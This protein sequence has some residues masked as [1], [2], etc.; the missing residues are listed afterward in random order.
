MKPFLEKFEPY[1]YAALRIVAGFLFLWHGTSKLFGFP[2]LGGGGH[3]PP[4]M[5]VA[6][7][8]ES[9]GGTLMLLGLFTPFAAF[10]ASGEMAV[11][12]WTAHAPH[13]L[14]PLVNQGELAALYCFLFLFISARGGGGFSLDALI[15]KKK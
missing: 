7:I 10:I 12:Y 2:P 3:L 9:C 13:A 4:M 15:F 11:A 6:G 8:V 1:L 14:L 5:L